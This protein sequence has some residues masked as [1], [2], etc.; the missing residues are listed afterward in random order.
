MFTKTQKFIIIPLLLV[1]LAVSLAGFGCKKSEEE[2]AEEMVIP[3]EPAPDLGTQPSAPPAQTPSSSLPVSPQD[4]P[5]IEPQD[6]L[7]KQLSILAQDFAKVW[8]TFSSDGNCENIKELL[9]YMS[10]HFRREM[11]DYIDYECAESYSGPSFSW[12]TEPLDTVVLFQDK[13]MAEILVVTERT[14]KTSEHTKTYYS[15]LILDLVVETNLKGED[16][17]RING[18]EWAE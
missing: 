4:E 17:W 9:G 18:A 12:Q 16:E 7:E 11:E 5:S 1:L 6:N 2:A 14:K 10:L 15:N 3:E 13:D 8:G